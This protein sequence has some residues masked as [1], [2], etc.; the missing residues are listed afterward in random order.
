MKALNS[1]FLITSVIIIAV[2]VYL[3]ESGSAWAKKISLWQAGIMGNGTYF[4]FLTVFIMALPPLLLLMIIKKM[5]IKI[6]K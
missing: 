6:V 2:A 3:T 5:L 4:P 1:I